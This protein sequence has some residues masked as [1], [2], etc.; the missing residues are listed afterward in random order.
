LREDE[1]LSA[2]S[3][4]PE[5]LGVLGA[6][7]TPS[8]TSVPAIAARIS[9]IAMVNQ[10]RGCFT[11]PQFMICILTS[12]DRTMEIHQKKN[13]ARK[14]TTGLVPLLRGPDKREGN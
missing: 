10:L 12:V 9:M 6:N 13:Q 1:S 2:D 11:S 5:L 8:S 14:L 7:P 4:P 3:V